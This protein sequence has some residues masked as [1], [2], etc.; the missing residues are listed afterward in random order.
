[1]NI[2][3]DLLQGDNVAQKETPNKDGNIDPQY[4]VFHYTAGRSA[5]SAIDWLC[6][7]DARAS[8]HVVLG[9]DGSITQLAPFNVKTW[10]AGKSHWEGLTGMNK[11]SI[12]IE[13]D[14][15]GRLSKV[16]T[17]YKAW[18]QAEYP[19]DEVIHAKHKFEQDFAFWHAYTEIQIERA[20]ELGHLLVQSYNLRD[21]L[22]HEDIAP[23]R[24]SDPGPAFP[25]TNIRSKLLGRQEEEDEIY[26]VTAEAL[27]IRRGPGI[28]FDPVSSPLPGGTKVAILEA[29]DR[30][31]KVDV[32][33]AN[34]IEGW[35]Y[36][37][38]IRK[39]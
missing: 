27:N 23:G 19:E 6:N 34:D 8:A 7:Q 12:S 37:K 18:F 35:V 11:Y 30:W 26:E 20:V 32:E 21:V 22:G 14:N 25:M 5:R 2:R 39:V 4:L 10:H 17:K 33:D 1:M 28:E 15:A 24:K 13:I 16:G 31:S 3:N 9:R 38:Y 29:R 36:N